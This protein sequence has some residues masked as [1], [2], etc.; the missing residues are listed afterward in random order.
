M[1]ICEHKK[2][3]AYAEDDHEELWY[4]DFEC[5]ECGIQLY[6]CETD[7]WD[8]KFLRALHILPVLIHTFPERNYVTLTTLEDCLARFVWI[9]S[10]KEITDLENLRRRFTP[11]AFKVAYGPEVAAWLRLGASERLEIE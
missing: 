10:S 3:I 4:M 8:I 11:A 7:P 5:N 9:K 1:T 6:S 2:A